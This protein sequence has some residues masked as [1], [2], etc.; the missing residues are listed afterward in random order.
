[1]EIGS[2]CPKYTFFSVEETTV[3]P[4]RKP[5]LFEA[6]AFR[7]LFLCESWVSF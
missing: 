6:A 1:V 4:Q 7:A 5:S 3:S 2:L